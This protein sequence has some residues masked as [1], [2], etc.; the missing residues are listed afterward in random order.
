VQ[1]EEHAPWLPLPTPVPVTEQGRA[2]AAAASRQPRTFVT[3]LRYPTGRDAALWGWLFAVYA[4]YHHKLGFA[5]T[6]VYMRDNVLAAFIQ[7]PAVVDAVRDGCMH[8]VRWDFVAPFPD[9]QLQ[10]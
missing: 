9:D 5:A 4:R 2:A 7:Q 8:V 1:G 6:V 10:V 3:V